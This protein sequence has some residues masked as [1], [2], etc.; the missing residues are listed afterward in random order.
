MRILPLAEAKAKLSQLVAEIESTDGEV[1][2]TRNGR[3]VA[4]LVSHEDFER[5]KETAEI[6]ADPEFLAEIRKGMQEIRKRR[7][8]RFDAAALDKLFR[9]S[10]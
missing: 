3:A 6:M 1:T 7:A 10:R 9:A 5:W 2:I 4:V 8:R